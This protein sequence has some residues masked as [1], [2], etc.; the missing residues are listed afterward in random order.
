MQTNVPGLL[1]AGDIRSNSIRQTIA[2]AGDGSVAAIYADR[3]LG[4]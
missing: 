3:Y 2:A 1:A 4:E